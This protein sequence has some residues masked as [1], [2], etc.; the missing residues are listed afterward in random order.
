[1]TSLGSLGHKRG[2]QRE[3]EEVIGKRRGVALGGIRKLAVSDSD[4]AGF[5]FGRFV[6]AR[7]LVACYATL[8]PALSVGRLVG[9]LVGR[10]HFLLF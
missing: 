8:H 3:E 2:V 7:F 9:R 1:M 10:S 4:E 5:S 6:R